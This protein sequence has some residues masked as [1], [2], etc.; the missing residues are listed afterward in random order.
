M[1]DELPFAE[2][3]FLLGHF[4]HVN[5]CEYLWTSPY[6]FPYKLP[7]SYF[8]TF[9]NRRGLILY[10]LPFQYV[11]SDPEINW[12]FLLNLK[13][14]FV[15]SNLISWS[16]CC[17]CR[18]NHSLMFTAPWLTSFL[19][20]EPLHMSLCTKYVSCCLNLFLIPVFNHPSLPGVLTACL[21]A[22]L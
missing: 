13:S 4:L 12:N 3:L 5:N 2:N 22:H 1:I 18:V 6:S 8:K 15:L 21:K 11:Y 17:D 19:P 16:P 20:L 7:S 10:Q 14:H 9:K